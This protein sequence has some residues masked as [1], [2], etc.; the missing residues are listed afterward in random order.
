MLQKEQHKQ[1][2]YIHVYY[3]GV[4][5]SC[6]NQYSKYIFQVVNCNLNRAWKS[7]KSASVQ[8]TKIYFSRGRREI[9][10][11]TDFSKPRVNGKMLPSFQGRNVCLLGNA[12]DVSLYSLYFQHHK[13]VPLQL[14]NKHQCHNRIYCKHMMAF[15]PHE[16]FIIFFIIKMNTIV[17]L[18]S[19]E[20][21][22]LMK[23]EA[24]SLN[25][26]IETPTPHCSYIINTV[27]EKYQCHVHVFGMHLFRLIF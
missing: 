26:T 11:M 18:I 25:N 15:L 19:Q 1:N 14:F 12:K 24:R 23:V 7:A 17:Y 4:Y 6:K 10:T 2:A 8:E 22:I 27:Q 13:L 20:Y 21:L 16:G 3:G 9:S 5:I